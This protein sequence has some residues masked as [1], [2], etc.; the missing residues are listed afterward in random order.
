[1]VA[2]TGEK[3]SLSDLN[4]PAMVENSIT[5]WELLLS[6]TEIC[7]SM[8]WRS[9]RWPRSRNFEYLQGTPA[10]SRAPTP[11]P[12]SAPPTIE[13]LQ[14]NWSCQMAPSIKSIGGL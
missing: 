5:L 4:G 10:P 11:L 9:W 12:A 3:I 2:I 14:Q 1:M 6:W 7:M 8:N 13:S